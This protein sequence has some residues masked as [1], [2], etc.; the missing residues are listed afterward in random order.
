MDLFLRGAIVLVL[1]IAVVGIGLTVRA[2]AR[3]R[4]T[5]LSGSL[6]P[7]QL[8]GRFDREG[9]GIVYFFGPVC[10]TCR[11]QAGVLDELS[12]TTEIPVVRVD[13]TSEAQLANALGV[14]TVPA[15]IVVD[16]DRSIRAVNLGVQP[17]DTLMKQLED[18][19][20]G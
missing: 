20:A 1:A 12:R 16:R 9:P 15:T 7:S 3:R 14:M 11:R 18:T 5:E 2:R 19:T 13:A 4:S 6:I 17:A 10:P 8:V